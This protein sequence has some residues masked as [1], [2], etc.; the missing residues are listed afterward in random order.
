MRGKAFHQSA[1]R[2]GT[3]TNVPVKTRFPPE[4]PCTGVCME[5]SFLT[6]A[7]ISAKF[8]ISTEFWASESLN[9]FP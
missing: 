5:A 8:N 4:V 9:T 2:P 7:S 3:V 1:G 6:D